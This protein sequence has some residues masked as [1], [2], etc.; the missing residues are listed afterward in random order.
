VSELASLHDL[1]IRVDVPERYF[2]ELEKGAEASVRFEALQGYEV[3]GKIEA[4]VPSANPQ[5]RTF[6]LKVRIAN[7]E[8]RIGAGMLAR[9]ALP[10]G[11]A[12][13]ALVV[14]KD[15]VVVRGRDRMVYRLEDDDTVQLVP[16]ETGAGVG[17]WVEIRAGLTPGARVVTRGNE[18]L[19]PGQ[20]V[21]GEVGEHGLP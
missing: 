3:T 4:I 21:V 12:Y 17:S 19:R 18:R 7:P 15:A 6:P 20:A 13:R 9:V 16:V 5:A 1:E 11:D 8:A 10:A 14:P 2:A